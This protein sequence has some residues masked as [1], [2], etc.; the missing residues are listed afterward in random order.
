MDIEEQRQ[1]FVRAARERDMDTLSSLYGAILSEEGEGGLKTMQKATQAALNGA[2]PQGIERLWQTTY[3]TGKGEPAW[4]HFF[5]KARWQGGWIYEG[6]SPWR[7]LLRSGR[8][9]GDADFDACVQF[10]LSKDEEIA[11]NLPLDLSEKGS[12]K[13]LCWAAALKDAALA[14]QMVRNGAGVDGFNPD[15]K[16]GSWQGAKPSETPL[17]VALERGRGSTALWLLE[18][19]ANRSLIKKSQCGAKAIQRAIETS[20]NPDPSAREQARLAARLGAKLSGPEGLWKS[21]ESWEVSADRALASQM[22]WDV[23]C[24]RFALE[25]DMEEPSQAKSL[26]IWRRWGKKT[27]TEPRAGAEAR[28]ALR[29]A[30]PQA[31]AEAIAAMAP[32]EQARELAR[33]LARARAGWWLMPEPREVSEPESE[34]RALACFKA[35][36]ERAGQATLDEPIRELRDINLMGMAVGCGE[37]AACA[38][39]VKAGASV[40]ASAIWAGPSPLKVAALLG[41]EDLFAKLIG[42]GADPLDGMEESE[43]GAPKGEHLT[44]LLAQNG[45][46]ERLAELLEQ[47]PELARWP[48]QE[49]RGLLERAIKEIEESSASKPAEAERWKSVA[50]LAEKAMLEV[51]DSQKSSDRKAEVEKPKASGRL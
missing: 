45:W 27:E 44:A 11:L 22:E 34:P 50:A 31:F 17:E 21:K 23:W 8:G 32:R 25:A 48:D 15:A 19:G 4:P 13:P 49:G 16:E 47:R 28:A 30:D 14:Q 5:P 12:W 1:A 6:P 42:M 36:L 24:A 7:E 33:A 40:S 37:I 29:Q 9:P 18:S 10:L 39:L 3:K 38:K 51:K 35:G 43:F 46:I 41:R 20:R 26:S 2:W